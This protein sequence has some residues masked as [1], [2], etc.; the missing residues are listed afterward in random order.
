ML[1]TCRRSDNRPGMEAAPTEGRIE[2]RHR[3]RKMSLRSVGSELFVKRGLIRGA[4][5]DGHH[6]A[7]R[8]QLP[9]QTHAVRS[10]GQPNGDLPLARSRSRQQ[11]R[12]HVRARD[13]QDDGRD[14][15]HHDQEKTPLLGLKHA[16]AVA[17]GCEVDSLLGVFVALLLLGPRA[18]ARC[19]DL[20]VQNRELGLRTLDR[21]AAFQ[22]SHDLRSVR[23][24][25]IVGQ[26]RALTTMGPTAR[27]TC[28]G[29]RE[30]AM[31]LGP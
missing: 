28:S 17:G 29:R 2:L 8:Q 13:E 24:G 1:A 4:A 27:W 3:F 19:E 21:D 22:P 12:C 20:S 26:D 11:Q 5:G 30:A 14:R 10:H 6:E 16:G 15:R 23:I 9:D 7:L 31:R 25:E 18:A